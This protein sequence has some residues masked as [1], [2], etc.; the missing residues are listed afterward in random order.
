MVPGSWMAAALLLLLLGNVNVDVLC[1]IFQY[2]L[3][4]V[5]WRFQR[6]GSADSRV[7]Q[8]PVK[9]LLQFVLQV[10]EQLYPLRAPQSPPVM[11]LK[12]QESAYYSVFPY[13]WLVYVEQS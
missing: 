6:F 5:I 8:L 3:L 1:C 10:S 13:C 11:Q 4:S 9:S 12:C 7:Y 2:I